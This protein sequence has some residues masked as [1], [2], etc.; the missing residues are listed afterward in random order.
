MPQT[1][2]K[3]DTVLKKVN[4]HNL[5]SLHSLFPIYFHIFHILNDRRFSLILS[6]FSSIHVQT[7]INA[8]QRSAVDCVIVN[9]ISKIRDWSLITRRRGLQNGTGGAS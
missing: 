8:A 5:Y 2:L 7:N 3:L 6:R 4:N 9:V 1:I